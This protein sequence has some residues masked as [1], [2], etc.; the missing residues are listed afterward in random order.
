MTIKVYCFKWGTKYG[1]EYV[2]RLLYSV[3]KNYRG[4]VMF[5][6]ITDDK[7]GLDPSINIIDYDSSKILGLGNVFTIEKLKLF[8]P[9]FI[10]AGQNI[11]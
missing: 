6:C 7:S 11:L 4:D 3:L 9:H 5:T 10:G 2:N 8:D 1:P